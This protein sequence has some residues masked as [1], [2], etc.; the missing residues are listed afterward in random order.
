[1]EEVEPLDIAVWS[2][3]IRNHARRWSTE[4]E[5]SLAPLLRHSFQLLQL[6]PLP[7]RSRIRTDASESE[8]EALLER[9]AFER[10]AVTLLGPMG[11][12]VIN[13]LGERKFEARVTL[14]GRSEAS[15]CA[16]SRASALL[17]AWLG[18]VA[19]IE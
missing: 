12:H 6:T 16:G 17:G 11:A 15:A 19:T 7:L 5:G 4:R 8:F 3:A 1:M 14:P 10:A 18:S 9:R 2:E 13:D